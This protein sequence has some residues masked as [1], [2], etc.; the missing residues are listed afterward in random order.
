[1]D[2][3]HPFLELIEANIDRFGYHQT[4]VKSAIEPRFAYTIGLSSVLDFELVFAGGLYYLEEDV[5]NIIAKIVEGLKLEGSLEEQNFDLGVLGAFRLSRVDPSWS[6]LMLLGVADY[7]KNVEVNALQILPDLT[8][9]TIDVPDMSVEWN[10]L[11]EPIWQWL[12]KPWDYAVPPDSTVITNIDALRGEG[13]TEVMRW[14][15]NEWEMFSGPGP[16]V[17]KKDVR[18][19]SLGTMLGI[20]ARLLPALNLEVNKGLWRESANSEWNDWGTS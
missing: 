15:V 14:D 2:E 7:Y 1:M 9:K 3:K 8:H 6:K 20:D 17:E 12:L 10:P 16:E 11:R 19:V 18:I 5:F 4:V 13:V